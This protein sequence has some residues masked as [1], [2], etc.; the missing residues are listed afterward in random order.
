MT[1][2]PTPATCPDCGARVLPAVD[3]T[4]EELVLL[5]PRPVPGGRVEVMRLPLSRQPLVAMDHITV[6]APRQPAY[7]LHARTCTN[8]PAPVPVDLDE[9]TVKERSG[10]W[11]RG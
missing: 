3:Y 6:P 11:R 7:E 2:T 4:T 9:D 5:N 1:A 8:P 10:G